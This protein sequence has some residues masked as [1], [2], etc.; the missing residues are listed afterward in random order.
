MRQVPN[1][2]EVFLSH[3]SETSVV[4]EI[5]E[6]VEEGEAKE[7][8]REAIKWVSGSDGW[9]RYIAASHA[10]R[11]HPLYQIPLQRSRT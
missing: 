1:T 10:D 8:L 11:T 7:D 4:I 2:Q 6:V 3:D 5:L 9:I